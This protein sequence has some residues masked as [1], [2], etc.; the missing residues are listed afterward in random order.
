MR[1]IT[2]NNYWL[3]EFFNDFIDNTWLPKTK[4]TA[5]AINVAESP[6]DYFVEIAAP[7]MSKE[8]FNIQINEDNDLVI[9]MEKKNES[10]EDEKTAKTTRYLRREFS[11]SKYLQT[12]ILPDD[13]DKKKIS[14][15]VE[16]GILTITL[17]KLEA[18]E[19]TKVSQQIIVS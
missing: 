11:Y 16:N 7:G 3:P 17:P 2:T 10:Q 12:L 15:K 19:E 14:A 1:Q 9:K 4:S 8:D 6:K 5:P 18:S 13:V